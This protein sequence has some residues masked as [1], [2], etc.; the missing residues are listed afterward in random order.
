MLLPALLSSLLGCWYADLPEA[1]YDIVP[2][3]SP[4][5]RG[6]APVIEKVATGLE[7]PDGEPAVFYAVYSEAD[8]GPSPVA[9]L[10]HSSA[11]DYVIYPKPE[12]EL[13][14]EHYAPSDSGDHRMSANWGIKKVWETL[15]VYR[16]IDT[17]EVN[18]GA[19]PAALL[20]A[21]FVVL[22]PINCWGDLWHNDDGDQRNDVEAE[23]LERFG[24]TFATW[25]IRVIEEGQPSFI[26][27]PE[28]GFAERMDGD[29]IYLAGLGDGARGVIDLLRDEEIQPRISGIFVDSPV[30]DL[31]DWQAEV[32]G[33]G[34]GLERI[35]AEGMTD[36]GL[37]YWSLER[38]AEEGLLDGLNLAMAWS[39]IDPRVPAGNLDGTL[40]ALP[41]GA[42]VHNAGAAAH[43]F[44]NADIDLARD[45][46]AAMRDG[47]GGP[48]C[49]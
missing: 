43:V 46:V 3:D 10:L 29:R 26:T 45:M 5:L 14:G 40:E 49:D 44:A 48:S 36:P 7:C 25:M 17:T 27:D 15:G 16:Q 12:G 4:Y 39:D 22:M 1:D 32:S 19:L 6:G 33:V 23:Y 28:L 11:F 42:C 35:F 47:A 20:E 31:D 13:A 2:Y 41:A 9:V 38:L 30:D 37:P 18:D 34:V 24:R 8:P 21:G